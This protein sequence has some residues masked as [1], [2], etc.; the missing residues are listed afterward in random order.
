L[1]DKALAG[2]PGL[3]DIRG[4]VAEGWHTLIF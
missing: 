2:T 3:S 1:K 4:Y